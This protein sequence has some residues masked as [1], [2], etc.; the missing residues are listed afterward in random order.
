LLD[1][2]RIYLKRN[3]GYIN[4]Y[5][6]FFFQEN[7]KKKKVMMFSRCLSDLWAKIC[8]WLAGLVILDISDRPNPYM[9]AQPSPERPN[10][11]PGSVVVSDVNNV[12]YHK[13]SPTY[14]V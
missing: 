3:Y 14:P 5:S 11:I 4:Y 12:S 13:A 1:L 2:H 6:S 8:L 10:L 7:F 9:P